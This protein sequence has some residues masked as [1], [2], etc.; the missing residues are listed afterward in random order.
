MVNRSFVGTIDEDRRG[1]FNH[2]ERRTTPP[3][4]AEPLVAPVRREA[5]RS[6]ERLR[7]ETGLLGITRT[8]T[9]TA[10]LVRGLDAVE[11]TTKKR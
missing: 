10:L 3:P 7:K 4:P 6:V 2:L 8:D 5:D 11:R 9:A 1:R